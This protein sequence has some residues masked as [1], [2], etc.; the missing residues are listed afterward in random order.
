MSQ[1]V[2]RARG[3]GSGPGDRGE[4]VGE[5]A[6][7]GLKGVQSRRRRTVARGLKTDGAAG[8]QTRAWPRPEAGCRAVGGRRRGRLRADGALGA[9][10][11][12]GGGRVPG[13]WRQPRAPRKQALRVE[14][15]PVSAGESGLLGAPSAALGGSGC[16][17]VG[18]ILQLCEF[19]G[20]R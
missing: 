1:A 13:S 12:C 6:G 16:D 15:S 4:E 3:G 20:S 10:P 9:R 14:E 11:G 5:R 18:I 2:T 19:V 7:A 8:R 17:S